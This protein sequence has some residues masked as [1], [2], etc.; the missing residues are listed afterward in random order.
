MP[1]LDELYNDTL[2]DANV[3]VFAITTERETDDWMKFIDE[4]ELSKEWMHCIDPE[5]RNP[6]RAI[7]DIQST[8][9]VFLIN[10]EKIIKA[11][12]I[13]IE[14]IPLLIRHL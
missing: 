12:R 9:M 7:Y 14:D 10:R 6:C 1:M 2:K 13:G 3:G 8:P 11:K 4:H 5:G